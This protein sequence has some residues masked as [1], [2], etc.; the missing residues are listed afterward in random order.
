LERD[1]VHTGLVVMIAVTVAAGIGLRAAAFIDAARRPAVAWAGI[2]HNRGFWI[3]VILTVPFVGPAAY[4]VRAR[5]QLE[6]AH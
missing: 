1:L 3:I 4:F 6:A 5:P 2:N